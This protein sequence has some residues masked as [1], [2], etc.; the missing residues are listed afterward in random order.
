LNSNEVIKFSSNTYS[1][2]PHYGPRIV[3]ASI[4]NEYQESCLGGGG[5]VN[6]SQRVRL[7]IVPPSVTQLSRQCGIHNV[8]QPY[9]PSWPLTGIASLLTSIIPFEHKEE[10]QIHA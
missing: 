4:R 6:C 1:F 8:S 2:Q 5:G 9:K 3:A 7:T 10:F